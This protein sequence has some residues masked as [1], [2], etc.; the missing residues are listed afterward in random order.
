MWQKTL[1]NFQRFK[2]DYL[3]IRKP[4]PIAP[5]NGP[6]LAFTSRI[7]RELGEKVNFLRF[8]LVASRNKLPELTTLPPKIIISGSRILTIVLSAIPKYDP[9]S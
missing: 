7:E 3:L 2:L 5:A 4:A 8:S 9:S 6:S 1:E